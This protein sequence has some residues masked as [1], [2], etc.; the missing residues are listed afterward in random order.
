VFG[1][2]TLVAFIIQVATGIA[3]ATAY[4]TST[5]NAY[6]S[7]NYITY[8]VIFGNGLRGMH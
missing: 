6:E 2:A 1:S 7:L 8:N 5:G 3:L 4:I